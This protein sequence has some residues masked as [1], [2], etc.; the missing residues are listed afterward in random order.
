MASIVEQNSQLQ[1]AIGDCIERALKRRF[2]DDVQQVLEFN[3]KHDTGF[4][5][6]ELVKSHDHAEAFSSFLTRFFGSGAEVV[7]RLVV[8]ELISTFPI[9]EESFKRRDLSLAKLIGEIKKLLI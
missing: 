1:D 3:F 8:Q 6:R 5:I 2:G 9:S 4:A 7:E